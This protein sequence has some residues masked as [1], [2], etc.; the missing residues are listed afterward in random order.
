MNGR[1]TSLVMTALLFSSISA[2]A[3]QTKKFTID[4]WNGIYANNTCALCGGPGAYN[5]NR[6]YP[7]PYPNEPWQ[8]NCGY[9]DTLPANTVVTGVKAELFMKDCTSTVNGVRPD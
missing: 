9:Q 1:K 2:F 8:P 4:C 3:Q 6:Y 7:G 5:S